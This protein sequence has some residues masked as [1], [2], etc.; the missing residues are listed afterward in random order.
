M[1]DGARWFIYCAPGSSKKWNNIRRALSPLGK[2]TQD[3]D[4][5]GII[6]I[7]Q[8]PNSELAAA[9]RKYEQAARHQP[10]GREG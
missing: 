3:G 5:E 8:L 9:I 10:R 2:C 1:G 6:R 7:D 4:D